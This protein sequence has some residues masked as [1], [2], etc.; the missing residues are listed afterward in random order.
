MLEL[1][2]DEKQG[3][4]KATIVMDFCNEVAQ[5]CFFLYNKAI[6]LHKIVFYIFGFIIFFNYMCSL[7]IIGGNPIPYV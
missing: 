3:D 1:H 5:V 2:K 7:Y 6:A 4:A